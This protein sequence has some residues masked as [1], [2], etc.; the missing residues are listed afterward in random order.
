MF[1]RATLWNH[2]V[3]FSWTNNCFVL[4]Q[5]EFLQCL[6]ITS[7]QCN[8]MPGYL[9]CLMML[10][11]SFKTDT[12]FLQDNVSFLQDGCLITSK[13]ILHSFLDKHYPGTTIIYIHLKDLLI[14]WRGGLY[15][16]WVLKP[17]TKACPNYS[18]HHINYTCTCNEK[19]K[20]EN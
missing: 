9:Q 7:H 5:V 15:F 4:P 18:I 17:E 1:H 14:V 8:L 6:V 11:H 2:T 3:S 12:L 13:M 10:P 16:P 20:S 19:Y